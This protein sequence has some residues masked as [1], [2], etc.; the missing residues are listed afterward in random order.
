MIDRKAK[1]IIATITAT[2]IL[3]IVSVVL[4]Q[5]LNHPHSTSDK[6][7]GQ[8]KSKMNPDYDIVKLNRKPMVASSS[9]EANSHRDS[10]QAAENVIWDLPFEK[11]KSYPVA[12]IKY[13]IPAS[14]SFRS[15]ELTDY[16]G[17]PS[18][19]L[20]VLG[21]PKGC[22]APQVNYEHVAYVSLPENNTKD[23]PVLKKVLVNNA[24]CE[25]E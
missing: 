5:S 3:V 18:I 19:I 10:I 1:L 4:Y 23:Y 20:T 22:A 14:H 12:F 21:S 13:S 24:T 11:I 6:T 17:E 25:L 8:D 15:I 2:C 7:T 16:K 9:K